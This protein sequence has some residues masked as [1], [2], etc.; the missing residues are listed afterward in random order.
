MRAVIRIIDPESGQATELPTIAVSASAL[1]ELVE[2]WRGR[3]A[4]VYGRA[5]YGY[6]VWR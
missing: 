6:A 3:A 2:Y 4:E 1:R 5:V